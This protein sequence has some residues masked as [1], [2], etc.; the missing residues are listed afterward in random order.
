[1]KVLEEMHRHTAME[2]GAAWK[3]GSDDAFVTGP[4]F[5][6]FLKDQDNRVSF[7]PDRFGAGMS[8]TN[9]QPNRAVEKTS[10]KTVD[11]AQYLVCAV[12]VA[13]GAFLIL[14]A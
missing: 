12:L 3:N 14:D 5:E 8:T 13:V 6:Q 4:Q 1:M 9:E 10:P 11:K 7:D 2:G